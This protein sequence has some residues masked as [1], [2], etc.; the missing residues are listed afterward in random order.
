MSCLS[1]ESIERRRLRDNT[2]D[3]GFVS[4]KWVL[5][6]PKG[7][8]SISTLKLRS[9]CLRATLAEGIELSRIII[10]TTSKASFHP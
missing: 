1:G 4:P 8:G 5:T 10:V 6:P 9:S 3:V 7:L 2:D